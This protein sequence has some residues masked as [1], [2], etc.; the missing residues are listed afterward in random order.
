VVALGDEA[1]RLELD[2]GGAS[3]LPRTDLA[4]PGA[5]WPFAV[6]ERLT[7]W[8]DHATADGTYLV[9]KTKADK[10]ALWDRIA[11]AATTQ[12]AIEGEVIG[13]TKG[14]LSVDIGIKA[15]L[16]ASQ[17]ELR[18]VGDLSGYAG[19]KLQ[20]VV[21][22][23][24]KG[25][26]NC[27]LSRRAV[28]ERERETLSRQTLDSLAVGQ[29]LDG[30]VVALASYGAFVD[31]GGIDGL[32]H[33]DELSWVRVTQ[34]AQVVS[35]GDRVR[36]KVLDVDREKKRISLST[37]QL[38]EDPWVAAAARYPAGARVTGPVVSL[39]DYG[40]FVRLEAGV[41]G[42]V[43]VSELSW[44]QRPTHPKNLVRVGEELELVVLSFDADQRRVSLS[45]KPLLP[46]PWVAWA[47][48]Y[49][50]GSRVKGT[51]RRFTDFGIFVE[52]EEGLD[53]LVR[54]ADLSWT[55][56]GKDAAARLK[57]G[58][59]LEAVV[60]DL[61]ADEQRLALSVK[62]LTEDPWAVLARKYPVGSRVTAKVTSLVDFGAFLEVEAGFEG[63]CH[64][65]QLTPNRVEKVADVLTV[66]QQVEVAVIGVDVDKRK[67][68]LSIKALSEPPVEPEEPPTTPKEQETFSNSLGDALSRSLGVR[69]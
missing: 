3:V 23:F 64:I 55:E 8:I 58:D 32:V 10:L 11:D 46:N 59:E 26:G 30:R 50:K 49:P 67:M 47:E 62:H 60:S 38:T 63:L 27:V 5:D 15:F 44:S 24:N 14:G 17:V 53:G 18:P 66:G 48:K 16:P 36:V 1:A 28:L 20:L 56:R 9:S 43:H 68:S 31:L 65:S 42:L 4:R 61:R 13:V 37:K 7:V 6:G 21:T 2:G 51:V 12:A 57:A 41:E 19:R 22:K 69:R 33:L 45:R 35:V 34:P 52:I 29:V 25:R 54:L 40:A 39:T